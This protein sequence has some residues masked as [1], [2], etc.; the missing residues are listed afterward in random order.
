MR[1]CAT[2]EFMLLYHYPAKQRFLH[3]EDIVP[4]TGKF[5][6][7]SRI[8]KTGIKKGDVLSLIAH[9]YAN[10]DGDTYYVA[11][12]TRKGKLLS[13]GRMVTH[14]ELTGKKDQKSG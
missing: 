6:A 2:H 8:R 11:Y 14:K 5:T 9:P 7:R 1:S 4:L 13:G 12:I 3:K 10:P